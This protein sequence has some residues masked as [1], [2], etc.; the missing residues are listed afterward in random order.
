MVDVLY[1]CLDF[2]RLSLSTDKYNLRSGFL[3]SSTGTATVRERFLQ[4]QT[5]HT[6]ADRGSFDEDF[7]ILPV[8]NAA[9]HE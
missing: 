2:L 4:S 8:I 5:V 9:V 3:E 7:G 6:T 1:I